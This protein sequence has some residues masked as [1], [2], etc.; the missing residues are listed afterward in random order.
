MPLYDDFR[1]FDIPI[2]VWKE[3]ELF[4]IPNDLLN[5]CNDRKVSD[6]GL[7]LEKIDYNTEECE[8]LMGER[9]LKYLAELK[10][11]LIIEAVNKIFKSMSLWY[12][13]Y[14]TNFKL[15][16]NKEYFDETVEEDFKMKDLYPGDTQIHYV[17]WTKRWISIKDFI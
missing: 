8:R 14:A 11:Q 15:E 7:Y 13:N 10:Q 17:V 6:Y 16:L 1:Q 4:D 2:E 9:N 3:K 12:R 5:F